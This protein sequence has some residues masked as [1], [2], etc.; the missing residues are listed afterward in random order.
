MLGNCLDARDP[1]LE[2]VGRIQ[3]VIPLSHTRGSGEPGLVIP[4]V[5]SDVSN[6]R[7][8]TGRGSYRSMEDGL[9]DVA[10]PNS[11]F[12]ER[13]QDLVGDPARMADFDD[14]RE[15]FKPRS[16][17]PEVFAILRFVL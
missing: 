1:R 12:R 6:R 13:I 7:S 5:Q 10:Q 4:A 17:L 8:G 15:L 16:Q 9:I 2:L 14:Q 3:I 11:E